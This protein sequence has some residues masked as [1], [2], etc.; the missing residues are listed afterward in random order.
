[1]TKARPKIADV[2]VYKRCIRIWA[3]PGSTTTKWFLADI[4]G[5]IEGAHEG[6]ALATVFCAMS[7]V[8]PA[9]LHLVDATEEDV[10]KT[11]KAI[12][13]ELELYKKDL[14]RKPEVVVLNKIDALDEKGNRRKSQ[15]T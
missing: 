5:L 6:S 2:S 8:V 11:Y 15:G 9:F 10:A 1:M 13:R 12:R 3:W 14:S 4:P 7:N